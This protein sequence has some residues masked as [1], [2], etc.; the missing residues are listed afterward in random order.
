[1][2]ENFKLPP[3]REKKKIELGTISGIDQYGY[4]YDRAK[5]GACIKNRTIHELCRRQP[6]SQG[7]SLL[8]WVIQKGKALGTRLCR[9]TTKSVS[10]GLTVSRQTAKNLTVNR[11]P[12]KK[13]KF[14]VK[15]QKRTSLTLNRQKGTYKLAV[16]QLQGLSNLT[17]SDAHLGCWLPKNCFSWYNWF[18]F[19]QIYSL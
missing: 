15:R 11:Q 13:G 17:I 6:R 4:A 2:H 18:P 14:T 3:I 12:S 10:M 5:F 19:S 9:R 16:K 8:N 7:F 1:M